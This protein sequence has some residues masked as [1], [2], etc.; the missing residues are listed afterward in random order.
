MDTKLGNTVFTPGDDL[1]LPDQAWALLSRRFGSVGETISLSE[2]D[3]E[4]ALSDT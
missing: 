4:V 2:E 3:G 1:A